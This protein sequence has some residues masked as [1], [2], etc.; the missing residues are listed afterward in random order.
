[1]A[2]AEGSLLTRICTSVSVPVCQ[3]LPV[4]V[5]HRFLFTRHGEVERGKSTVVYLK[6]LIH[7]L[8]VR[9]E[10]LTALKI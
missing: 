3:F 1:M 10:V 2:R 5:L 6:L 7:F 4:P 8:V 9:S